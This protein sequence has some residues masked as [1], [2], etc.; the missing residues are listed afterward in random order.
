MTFARWLKNQWLTFYPWI[1]VFLLIA[2]LA[3]VLKRGEGP[4]RYEVSG[5]AR[6][7]DGDSLFVDGLEIRLQHIDAPEGRQ[8]C[9]RNGRDWRCGEEATR[10]LRRF[11][12]GRP[13]SCKGNEYDRFGRL[14]AICRVAGQEINKWMVASGWAVA[15]GGYRREEGAAIR[16]KKGIWASAFQRPRQ[17]RAEHRK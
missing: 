5:R 14:L 15:F 6:V 10:R 7:V 2:A 17:W 1:R 11:V 3:F 13:L 16:A 9:R 8:T 12:A 4:P